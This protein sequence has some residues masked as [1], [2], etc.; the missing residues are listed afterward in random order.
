MQH[1]HI[2]T[3]RCREKITAQYNY[4]AGGRHSVSIKEIPNMQNVCLTGE[5]RQH[6]LSPVYKYQTSDAS[7]AYPLKLKICMLF[8]V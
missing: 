5:L 4:N 8:L 6:L 1:L 2:L 7:K 3:K